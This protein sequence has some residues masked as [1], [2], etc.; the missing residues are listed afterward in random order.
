MILRHFSLVLGLLL[1]ALPTASWTQ[2]LATLIADSIAVDPAG[3]ILATG[4]VEVFF[5]GT[6]LQA[7]TI[8]YAQNGDQLTITGPIRVTNPEGTLIVADQATLDR[9]L[10]NGVLTSARM[11][12]D[13][14]LQ[15]AATEIARV[16]ARYS[17]LDNVVASSCQVCAANPTPLWEIRARRVIHD[18]RDRQLY[19]EGAQFR[20]AGVP[21]LYFPRL[22]LP[23]P[24]VERASGFLIPNFSSSSTLGSGIDIGYFLALGDH[25]D[26]TVTPY[27]S[28][29]TRTLEF[30]YRHLTPN[31]DYAIAAAVSD[32]DIQGGRGYLFAN[33]EWDLPRGFAASGQLQFVSDAGYLF[34]YGYSELDR[35]TNALALER[36][37]RKDL[38][39]ASASEF[40][41]LRESEIGDQDTLPDQFIELAYTREIPELSF[42]GKTFA[43]V[44]LFG[45]RRPSSSDG[46]GRDVNRLS[47]DIS[48]DRSWLSTPGI[49]ANAELGLRM[50]AYTV[51]QDNAFDDELIRA[52]P[53]A[54][55]ELRWPM[56]RTTPTG[57]HEVLE[58]ILR[59]DWANISGDAVP[60]EDSRVVEFDEANLFSFSRYPGVDGAEQGARLA[61]GA[62]WHRT[63]PAGWVSDFAFGRVANLSGD[64]GFGAGSGLEGDQSEWLL[65]GRVSFDDSL[66]VL[67]RSLFDRNFNFTLS[68]TRVDWINDRMTLGT[69]YLY[70]APEPSEDRTDRLSEW[71]FDSSYQLN[72]RWTANADWRYDFNAGRASRSGF[73]L[74]Y[75]S[76]CV[77]LS[78][79]LSRRYADSTSVDPTTEVGFQVSLTGLAGRDSAQSARRHC[80]G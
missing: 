55:A 51:A 28:T 77:D 43:S 35:L 15:L 26:L 40:R 6:R 39:R 24:S 54:A 14:Q 7:A 50:D 63:G 66:F 32:D 57:G 52:V 36:V 73:G 8:R 48:W 4:N 45:L 80:K 49:V 56:A 47:A 30:D 37:R 27:L 13:Q 38:F 20:V 70:A 11:V 1:V 21:V 64:L 2:P 78:L 10:R 74:G 9:D 53:R 16:D 69:H 79:S 76:D 3:E 19:F 29:Q 41:T 59:L 22:R 18:E 25:A 60:N 44:G 72:D 71:S 68:E 31:A 61:L 67:S 23:D 46:L 75:Q 62:L 17:R 12:L 34:D 5:D 65:S 33:A 42:G 58:P